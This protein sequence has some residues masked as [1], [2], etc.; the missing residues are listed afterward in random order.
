MYSVAS[1]MCTP[2][3]RNLVCVKCN[4]LR[5]YRVQCSD[6]R[7]I[8]IDALIGWMGRNDNRALY[9]KQ[10]FV[11]FMHKKTRSLTTK[12]GNIETVFGR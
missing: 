7:A 3:Y 10:S 6:S 2:C 5:M 11:A 9:E 4:T 8:V 12:M 1:C